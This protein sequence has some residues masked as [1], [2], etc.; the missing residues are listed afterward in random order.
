M[1]AK[2][3]F[4]GPELRYLAGKLVPHLEVELS[5]QSDEPLS[6]DDT[7]FT[8]T[9]SDNKSIYIPVRNVLYVEVDSFDTPSL[10]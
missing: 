1:K 5:G 2:V 8:I 10:G 3:F 9:T 7:Q 6:V 4:K